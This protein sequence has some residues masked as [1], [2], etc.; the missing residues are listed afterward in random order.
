VVV[1]VVGELK[2]EHL[3][4]PEVGVDKTDLMESVQAELQ[5]PQEIPTVRL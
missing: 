3:Q 5:V 2:A 1:A 4:D